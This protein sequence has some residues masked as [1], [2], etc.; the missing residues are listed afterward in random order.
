MEVARPVTLGVV[1]VDAEG[2]CDGV[3]FICDV[4]GVDCIDMFFFSLSLKPHSLKGRSGSG[5]GFRIQL[6]GVIDTL[7]SSIHRTRT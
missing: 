4:L 6:L 5:V 7:S 3:S 2:Q 1:T